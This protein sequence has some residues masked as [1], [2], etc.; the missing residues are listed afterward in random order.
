MLSGD[1]YRGKISLMGKH[2]SSHSLFYIWANL[3]LAN[4]PE[5]VFSPTLG[6]PR[7]S[8]VTKRQRLQDDFNRPI[9]Q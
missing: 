2:S 1:F 3:V 4:D 9:P 7:G 8:R 5:P 6:D